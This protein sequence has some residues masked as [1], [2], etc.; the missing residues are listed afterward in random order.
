MQ[1]D[2][3]KVGRNWALL[4]PDDLPAVLVQR[5]TRVRAGRDLPEYI[6]AQIASTRFSSYVDQTK[7]DPAVPHITM[8]DVA[9]FPV[10]IPSLTE[11]REIVAF[12]DLMSRQFDDLVEAATKSVALMNERRSAL[13]SAAV[14]GQIDV[15][16][17]ARFVDLPTSAS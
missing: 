5:V 16:G 7:T 13:I 2:G 9:K 8:K 6:Y 12:V 1:M 3:S 4:G 10:V 11:Q 14:T 15:R 17:A